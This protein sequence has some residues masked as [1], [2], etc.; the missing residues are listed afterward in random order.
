[1]S[2]AV[3]GM[4]LEITRY[5]QSAFQK[6][7]NPEYVYKIVLPARGAQAHTGTIEVFDDRVTGTWVWLKVLFYLVHSRGGVQLT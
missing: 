5:L 7:P 2:E 4:H 3:G 1:M 6:P